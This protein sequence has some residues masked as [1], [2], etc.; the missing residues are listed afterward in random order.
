[1]PSG[2]AELD[3]SDTA[4]RGMFAAV[5]PR[6]D[7]LNHVLSAGFDLIWRRR[8]AASLELAPGKCVLDLCCGT[9]DQAIALQK[10]NLEVVAAD[11]CLPMLTL[12]QGKYLG[13][14][15]ERPRGLAADALRLPIETARFTGVTVAFGLRNVADLDQALEE[16]ARVLEPGGRVA[17]LE[18]A[19]PRN[20][21]VR[22]VYLLYFRHLLPSIGRWLS[23]QGS[24]Y[25]Y[26]AAS[27]PDFP[28]REAFVER[29]ERA[30]FD[31]AGWQD[32][33][34]GVVCLYTGTR[35]P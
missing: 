19:L 26:L 17:L 34:T 30:G 22:A 31:H 25:Q 2:P 10:Q 15:G 24:A 16:I 3:K 14:N 12:A 7:L 11:F 33:S 9:G 32:L 13:L 28:Q 27:V 29:M 5:A 23:P 18:F 1:M 6:Y 20:S 8:A 21:I 4:I 35:R